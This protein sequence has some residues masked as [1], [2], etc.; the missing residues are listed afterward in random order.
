MGEGSDT[1][2]GQYTVADRLHNNKHVVK[3]LTLE[4]KLEKHKHKME[5]LRTLIGCLVLTMQAIILYHI[6]IK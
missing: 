4:Q 6:I 1:F 3:K 2:T 5:L